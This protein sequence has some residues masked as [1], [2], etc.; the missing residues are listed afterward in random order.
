MA[1]MD[2][3]VQVSDSQL[4]SEVGARKATVES[5]LSR[6][7]KAGALAACLTN[8]PIQAKNNDIKVYLCL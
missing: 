4:Q 8:P 5:F 2:E 6:K 3:G 1:D 7:D